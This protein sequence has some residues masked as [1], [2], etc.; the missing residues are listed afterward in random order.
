M[1]E[2]EVCSVNT[3]CMRQRGVDYALKV[4]ERVLEDGERC[5]A[6]S[7]RALSGATDMMLPI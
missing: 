5:P 2:S 6:T 1:S 4:H 7:A 3:R